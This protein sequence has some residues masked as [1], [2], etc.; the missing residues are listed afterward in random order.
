MTRLLCWLF[1]H[2]PGVWLPLGTNLANIAT[3]V[4][5]RCGQ[6]VWR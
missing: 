3:R 1:G 5:P 2:K 6:A 4:C